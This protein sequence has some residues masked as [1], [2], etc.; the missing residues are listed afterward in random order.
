ME[1]VMDFEGGSTFAYEGNVKI[2]SSNIAYD[3]MLNAPKLSDAS[4]VYY[5]TKQIADLF[6]DKLGY[7]FNYKPEKIYL[8]GN[9]GTFHNSNPDRIE[10]DKADSSAEDGDAPENREWHEFSHHTMYDVYGIVPPQCYGL[11]YNHHGW[12]NPST[13]DAFCEGFAEFMPLVTAERNNISQ[14]WLY[15]TDNGFTNMENNYKAS[16][17]WPSPF[18]GSFEEIAVA[19]L[20]WDLYDSNATYTSHS[21][22]DDDNVTIGINDIWNLL[23][24]SHNL[25]VR[26]TGDPENRH[27]YYVQDLYD[28]LTASKLADQSGID[29][30]FAAHGFPKGQSDIPLKEGR[31]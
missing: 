10:I 12:M 28:V 7:V 26:Y 5:Y 1:D 2:A 21:G 17:G 31:Y 23:S 13:S 25:T 22:Y 29:A 6:T 18:S 24:T 16:Q 3:I 11:I 30:I 9:N 19:G 4:V 15:V 27:I 20:L 8:F 14:S